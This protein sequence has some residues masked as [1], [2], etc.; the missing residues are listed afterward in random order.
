MTVFCNESRHFLVAVG[1]TIAL[2]S[3]CGS[4]DMASTGEEHEHTAI[5]ACD[6]ASPGPPRIDSAM[7]DHLPHPY[8][9]DE[10]CTSDVGPGLADAD[11]VA[12]LSGLAAGE[13]K[14]AY[15]HPDEHGGLKVLVGTVKSGDGD[16]FVD[17]FLSRV[18]GAR[19]DTVTLGE[20]VVHYFNTPGGDG[21]AYADGPT[22]V[23]GYIPPPSEDP[24][25]TEVGVKE[26]FARIVAAAA[27]TPIPVEVKVRNGIESYPPGRGRYTTPDDPGWVFFKTD[28]PNRKACGIGPNGAMAGCD[29]VPRLNVGSDGAATAAPS[30]ANQTVVDASA[31]ARYT[32]SDT[33][34][35]TRDVDVLDEGHRLDNGA[36][37]CG[38]GYQGT[39]ECVTGDHSFLVSTDFGRL[40]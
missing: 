5:A 15:S 6:V 1:V 40:K 21:Y 3:A 36:A 31:P 12:E 19:N 39:V 26:V 4:T 16:A 30:G 35:F 17:M 9:V 38:A 11:D 28:N 25:I 20:H 37:T 18:G 8:T 24:A 10:I 23:V 29:I 27:G 34:T 33:P 2:C 22:V 13:I 32:H 7:V 14:N